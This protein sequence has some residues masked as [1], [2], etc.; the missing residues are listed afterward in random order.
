ML[1]YPALNLKESD[2]APSY[3]FAFTDHII[4]HKILRICLEN[5]IKKD[6][7]VLDNDPNVS[8]ISIPGDILKKLVK[9]MHLFCGDLDILRDDSVRFM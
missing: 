7:E 1:Y 4:T 8:P 6:M 3:L 2:F 9:K 5:Y